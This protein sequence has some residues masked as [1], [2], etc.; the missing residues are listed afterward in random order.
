MRKLFLTIFL[1]FL[2]TLVA[3]GVVLATVFAHTGMSHSA[4]LRLTVHDLLLFSIAGAIF[5][6]CAASSIAAVTRSP[7]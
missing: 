5:S 1:W 6:N 3:V 7:I 4:I 2:L